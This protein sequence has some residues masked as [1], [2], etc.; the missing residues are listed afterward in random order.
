VEAKHLE[1]LTTYVKIFAI[2]DDISRSQSRDNE[3][4]KAIWFNRNA[5]K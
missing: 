4:C 3:G 5:Q 1:L 2:A